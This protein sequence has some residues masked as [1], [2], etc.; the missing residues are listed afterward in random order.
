MARE[1]EIKMKD[2]AREWEARIRALEDKIRIAE[3]ES[4][5][6]ESEIRKNLEKK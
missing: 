2:I 5:S 1:H 3:G 4:S 6:L